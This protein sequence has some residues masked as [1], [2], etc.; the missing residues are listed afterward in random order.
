MGLTCDQLSVETSF[1]GQSETREED[2]IGACRV[3][4]A[5][6]TKVAAVQIREKWAALGYNLDGPRL[7]WWLQG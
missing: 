5:T 3:L 6:N 2:S 7:L 1:R 4:T